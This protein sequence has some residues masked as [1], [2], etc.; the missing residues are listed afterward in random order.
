MTSIYL[1]DYRRVLGQL[2]EARKRPGVTQQELAKRLRRPQSF[3]SKFENGE[4]RLDVVEFVKIARLVG[5]E[6]N[7]LLKTIE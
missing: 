3:V 7:K 5:V 6:P 2:V 1:E 4:R